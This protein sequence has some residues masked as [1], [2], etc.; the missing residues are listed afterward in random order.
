VQGLC[1]ESDR[2]A[3]FTMLMR[4]EYEDYGRVIRDANIE[5]E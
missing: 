1:P 2:G 3:E 4:K 5:A